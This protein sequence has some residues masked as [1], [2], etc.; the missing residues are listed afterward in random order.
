MIS[1]YC[2]VKTKP[3]WPCAIA[4]T[5]IAI[6]SFSGTKSRG[7][8]ILLELNDIAIFLHP[9]GRWSVIGFLI[10]LSNFIGPSDA[11]TLYL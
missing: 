10:T 7:C 8:F 5:M 9:T 1:F 6:G 2:N 11:R 3:T 4:P